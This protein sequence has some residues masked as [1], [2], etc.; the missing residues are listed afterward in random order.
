[1]FSQLEALS[2]LEGLEILQLSENTIT[3][4]SGLEDISTLKE[5]YLNNN[6][7]DDRDI[8]RLKQLKN[9]KTLF[10]KGNES[11][12]GDITME[13]FDVF[14]TLRYVD[15]PQKINPPIT[16]FNQERRIVGFLTASWFNEALPI[17]KKIKKNR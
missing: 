17:L 10:L 9:L 7:L 4:T 13:F 1:M 12:L 6:I 16:A 15:L 5:L 11:S 14:P 8:N 3:S 2:D